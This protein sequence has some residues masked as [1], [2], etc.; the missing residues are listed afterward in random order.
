MD[1]N[2]LLKTVFG[3]A[4]SG[5]PALLLAAANVNACMS[6]RSWPTTLQLSYSQTSQ[7]QRQ[8]LIFVLPDICSALVIHVPVAWPNHSIVTKKHNIIWAHLRV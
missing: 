4:F 8:Q 6:Q 2:I 3:F 5:S 1:L 7:L